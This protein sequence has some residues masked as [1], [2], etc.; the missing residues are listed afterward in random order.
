MFRRGVKK[1]FLPKLILLFGLLIPGSAWA[2]GISP[3][4]VFIEN[5]AAGTAV[6]TKIF[7]SRGEADKSEQIQVVISGEA[8][9]YIELPQGPILTMDSGIQLLEIPVVINTQSLGSGTYQALFTVTPYIDP[10]TVIGSGAGS[11]ILAGAQ[12]KI[13]FTVTNDAVELYSVAAVEMGDTEEGQAAGFSFIVRNEGNVDTRPE[14]IVI[15][16]T[17]E[18]D[19]TNTYTET[20][21][22]DQINIVP[23]F[24]SATLN[25]QTQANLSA[26]LYAVVVD[27]FDKQGALIHN[28]S[29]LRLQVFPQGTL[30]QAGLLQSFTTDKTSYTAGEIVKFE[31]VFENTGTIGTNAG[32]V[33]EIFKDGSRVEVLKP[34]PT[35]VPINKSATIEETYRPADGGAYEVNGYVSYAVF[36]SNE[37]KTEFSVEQLNMWMVVGFLV[38]L[39]L[40]LGLII[41]FIHKRAQ[42]KNSFL[43]VNH[44]GMGT[45]SKRGQHRKSTKRN[46]RSR[47]KPTPK[48][49]PKPKRKK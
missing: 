34:E 23:A 9:Q 36:K 48:F 42:K 24:S 16:F 19:A 5:I 20:I 39:S 46:N 31:A 3:A 2:V 49:K 27:F 30:A 8:A 47:S 18:Q 32:L 7:V 11:A 13:S 4:E 12:G 35:F 38:V 21:G 10:T 25:I 41:F 17:D 22:P 45:K 37:I 33:I 40:L 15:T 43:R 44:P 6:E 26:G 14:K 1:L 29:S 28:S